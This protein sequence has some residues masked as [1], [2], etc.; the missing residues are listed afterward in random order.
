MKIVGVTGFGGLWELEWAWQ[1]YVCKN[2]HTEIYLFYF[3]CFWDTFCIQVK[4]KNQ[5]DYFS[6]LQFQQTN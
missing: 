2:V 1:M 5:K 6:T 3:K 4:R